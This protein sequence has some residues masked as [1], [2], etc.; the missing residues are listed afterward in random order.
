MG[1]NLESAPYIASPSVNVTWRSGKRCI[2]LTGTREANITINKEHLSLEGLC[3]IQKANILSSFS[4]RRNQI[5]SGNSENN[6]NIDD[7]AVLNIGLVNI[8][9]ERN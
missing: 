2:K 1:A 4:S 7:K 8:M 9:Y 3:W 5:E 6:I